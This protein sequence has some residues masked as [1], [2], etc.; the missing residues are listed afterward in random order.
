[1]R[2]I[3]HMLAPHMF[4]LLPN[5]LSVFF[6]IYIALFQ[7]DLLLFIFLVEHYS[8]S[9][10]TF[11]ITPQFQMKRKYRMN[12]VYLKTQAKSLDCNL[13]PLWNGIKSLQI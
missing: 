8:E 2:Q 12:L 5:S 7:K 1:M 13:V 11:L 3:T 6:Y 10:F 4:Y 9:R